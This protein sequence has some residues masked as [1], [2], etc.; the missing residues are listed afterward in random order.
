MF[1]GVDGFSPGT[2][3]VL[4][5]FQAELLAGDQGKPCPLKAQAPA[6]AVAIMKVTGVGQGVDCMAAV[7][8]APDV[9]CF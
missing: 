4:S 3:G 9:A 5:M 8:E 2:R 6:P 7:R 1:Q